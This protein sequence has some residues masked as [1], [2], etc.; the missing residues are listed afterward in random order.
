[1]APFGYIQ[2]EDYRLNRPSIQPGQTP[3][4]P[5]G[6]ST[7]PAPLST[8]LASTSAHATTSAADQFSQD[9][10]LSSSAM[11]GNLQLPLYPLQ[12]T[13]GSPISSYKHG[14]SRTTS[15]SPSAYENLH[16]FHPQPLQQQSLPYDPNS[17][18]N[19]LPSTFADLATWSP[20]F[21]IPT[22]SPNFLSPTPYSANLD[23]DTSFTASSFDDP[24]SSSVKYNY[25]STT[26][27]AY[28]GPQF[29]DRYPDPYWTADMLTQGTNGGAAAMH[30]SGLALNQQAPLMQ[31]LESIGP[32]EIERMIS[33]SNA[34]FNS[35]TAR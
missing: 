9:S 23:L 2:P 12:T 5:S 3:V 24:L 1:M 35:R 33:E 6:R 17:P 8:N 18:Y 14:S 15:Q 19:Q 28:G 10:R 34:F 21:V 7:A 32:R 22:I 31:N 13:P 26:S 30:G 20:N 11:S 16:Y 29:Q 25:D 4:T 27:P